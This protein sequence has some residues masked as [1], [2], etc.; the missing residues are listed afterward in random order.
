MLQK[1]E[2][3]E[4]DFIIQCHKEFNA[5]EIGEKLER[6]EMSIRSMALRLGVRFGGSKAWTKEECDLFDKY[7]N[8]QIIRMTGRSRRSVESK[9]YSYQSIGD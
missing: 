3:Y 7:T 4:K 1:W 9:R 2:K 5:K 8:N 6:S